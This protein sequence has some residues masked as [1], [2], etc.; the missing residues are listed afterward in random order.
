[1]IAGL[2][3]AMAIGACADYQKMAQEHLE[4]EGFSDLE[5][6]ERPGSGN[7]YE[8]TAQKEGNP[9]R[10]SVTAASMPGSSSATFLVDSECEDPEAKKRANRVDPLVAKRKICDGGDLKVCFELGT[11]LV[12]GPPGARDLQSARKI[13]KKACDKDLLAACAKLGTLYSRGLGGEREEPKAQAL[14]DKACNGGDMAGCTDLAVLHY[15]NRRGK[16]AQVLFKKACDNGYFRGCEGLGTL[17]RDGE[18]VEQDFKQAKRLF[19]LACQGGEMV[20]CTNLGVMLLK[21][22]GGGKNVARAKEFL[23]KACEA[24]VQPACIHYKRIQ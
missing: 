9:C 12:D 11:A 8:F 13:L 15:I 5:L 3:L 4:A 14:F 20:G 18:G 19:E 23:K 16:E 2:V 1:M 6:T 22:E 7:A 17:Y 21:G 24:K 10:G